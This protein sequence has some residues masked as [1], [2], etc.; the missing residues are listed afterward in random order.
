MNSPPNTRPRASGGLERTK[1]RSARQEHSVVGRRRRNTGKRIGWRRIN[2]DY[3]GP[4]LPRRFSMSLFPRRRRSSQI[5]AF[6]QSCAAPSWASANSAMS[7]SLRAR[8]RR[9][10]MQRWQRQYN[11]IRH[12]ALGLIHG[13][14]HP[15][16]LRNPDCPTIGVVL[17]KI[18]TIWVALLGLPARRLDLCF[19]VA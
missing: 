3:A 17:Q 9:G 18:Y 1:S 19:G 11:S 5:F 6:L 2:L 4:L 13:H 16:V 14:C 8:G 15:A 10:A 12:R 7:R